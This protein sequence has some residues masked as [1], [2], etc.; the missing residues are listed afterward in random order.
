MPNYFK[1]WLIV[2]GLFTLAC[3]GL[4]CLA[5]QKTLDAGKCSTSTSSLPSMAGEPC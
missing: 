5:T 3:I 4:A 2:F 1:A